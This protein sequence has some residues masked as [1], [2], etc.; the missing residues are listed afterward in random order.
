MNCCHHH[1]YTKMT[2]DD[3]PLSR[4]FPPVTHKQGGRG[5]EAAQPFTTLRAFGE[6]GSDSRVRIRQDKQQMLSTEGDDG[7]REQMGTCLLHLQQLPALP[8]VAPVALKSAWAGVG[9]A[10]VPLVGFLL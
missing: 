8:A 1:N 7:G 9:S 2:L 6:T 4:F 5:W 10:W 3:L